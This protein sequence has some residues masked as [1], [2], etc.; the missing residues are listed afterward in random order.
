[1]DRAAGLQVAIHWRVDAA[2]LRRAGHWEHGGDDVTLTL[3]LAVSDGIAR[4][5]ATISAGDRA[6]GLRL[7][8]E[9]ASARCVLSEA[10]G[11]AHVDA[12][13][14]LRAT[15][16][17]AERPRV[18]YAASGLLDFLGLAGGRYEVAGGA[19]RTPGDR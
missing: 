9:L 8:R 5:E 3:A 13:P 18:L 19:W 2:S 12:P 4:A 6:R 16:G 11:L 7:P 15:V 10:D 17:A 1:L 14:V